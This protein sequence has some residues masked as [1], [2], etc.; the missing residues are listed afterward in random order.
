MGIQRDAT[1]VD[2]LE[3]LNIYEPGKY[4]IVFQGKDIQSDDLLSEY[5]V[6][7]EAIV[8]ISYLLSPNTTCASVYLRSSS[9]VRCFYNAP[10]D[11]MILECD[12]ENGIIWLN[13]KQ[14][15]SP[16]YR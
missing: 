15:K 16:L 7:A 11:L 9:V 3:E 12:K 2:L 1:A 5:G 8:E 10:Y 4:K 13:G 6:G 14:L